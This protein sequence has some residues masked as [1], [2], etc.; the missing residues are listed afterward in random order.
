MIR[1]AIKTSRLG[2]RTAKYY[3]LIYSLM[4]AVEAEA[5]VSEAFWNRIL[6]NNGRAR[7]VGG[8]ITSGFLVA[9]Y[10]KKYS[11]PS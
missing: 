1:I 3:I 9:N 5:D 7:R 4:N 2:P 11:K 8:G 10:L 6:I